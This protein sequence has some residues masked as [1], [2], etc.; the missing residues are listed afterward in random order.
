MIVCIVGVKPT[1]V[2]SRRAG[3]SRGRSFIGVSL[4]SFETYSAHDWRFFW[5]KRRRTFTCYHRKAD[6]VSPLNESSTLSNSLAQGLPS[7]QGFP[8]FFITPKVRFLGDSGCPWYAVI[9]SLGYV[10]EACILKLFP[11]W[12]WKKTVGR[13]TAWL[14]LCHWW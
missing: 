4:N 10:F 11:N 14:Y 7:L 2:L 6:M 12:P 5:L 8:A 9:C 13:I 3:Q 1:K